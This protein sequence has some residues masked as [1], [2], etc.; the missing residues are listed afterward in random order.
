[1]SLS[2]QRREQLSAAAATSFVT[3]TNGEMDEACGAV[4]AGAEED[5]H[6]ASSKAVYSPIQLRAQN[7][8]LEILWQICAN[9]SAMQVVASAC[10]FRLQARKILILF[11]HLFLQ[12][13]II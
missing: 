4:M 8:S 12:P 13:G 2:I 1:M 10:I 6:S 5:E 9:F 11:R 3:A 7:P